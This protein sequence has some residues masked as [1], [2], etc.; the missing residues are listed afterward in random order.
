MGDA[1]NDVDVD[2]DEDEDDVVGRRE[3]ARRLGPLEGKASLLIV[4]G[5]GNKVGVASPSIL[6]KRVGIFTCGLSI[7]PD[8]Q[9]RGYAYEAL[10]IILKFYFNKSLY[11]L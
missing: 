1:D 8:Y 6:D 10:S 9:R 5:D 3:R 4:D 2:A 7:K 11:Y